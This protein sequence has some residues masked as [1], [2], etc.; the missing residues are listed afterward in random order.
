[1]N[2]FA[3]VLTKLFAVKALLPD[4]VRSAFGAVLR[5]EWTPV[6]VASFAT[7]L[8]MVGETESTLVAAAL[9]LRDTMVPVDHKFAVV[10][11][12]CGTGGDGAYTLNLSSA[13]AIVVAAS[14]L[15]V[16][17]HGNRSVSS[18]CGS[19]DV[20]E[21]LGIPLDVPPERQTAVLRD[22]GIAFLFAPAHHPALRFAVQAR[23]ELG[24]RTVFNALGPLVNPAR[25]TH[26]I[27]GVY[28][29]ALRV[30]MAR[31]LGALGVAHAWVVH[32]ED[33]LDEVSPCGP[34]R[35]SD[36]VDGTVVERRIG[37]EDFGLK[38]V[39][40]EAI[41]GTDAVGNARIL[42]AILDGAEHPARDAILLNAAA[43]RVVA[44]GEPPMEAV[45]RCRQALPRASKTLD[46][47]KAIAQRE[48]AT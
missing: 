2:T 39:A 13:A 1:M 19:A 23:R 35:V 34:T 25:A 7:A 24:V 47:W 30:P 32:G 17:K 29:D 45:E 42:R 48:R 12:T 16:A 46:M 10:V 28:D 3:E 27:V 18:H 36:V 21:A 38:P 11:D 8:R 40:P 44:T 15:V 6:Q 20:F 41:A 5:G 4:D 31:A 37:P 22:A 26:Q 43:A 9:A 33:G 14:G